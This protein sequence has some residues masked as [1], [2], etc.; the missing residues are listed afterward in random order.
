LPANISL[1]ERNPLTWDVSYSKASRGHCEMISQGGMAF[2]FVG[3]RLLNT[4]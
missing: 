1:V 4:S 3:A 2:S